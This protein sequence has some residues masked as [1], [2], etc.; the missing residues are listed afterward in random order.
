METVN[1]I[2]E[3]RATMAVGA[4]RRMETIEDSITLFDDGEEILPGILARATFGH[5]PGH[6]SFELRSGSE[7]VMVLGDAITTPHVG[8][9]RPGWES[10]SDQDPTAGAATRVRL[11][12]QLAHEQMILVGYHLPGGGIGRA[13]RNGDTYR[14]VPQGS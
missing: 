7:S 2:P 6:M 13:E 12:D 9:E 10:G 14:F 5:T 1:T 8:F 3:A 11:L 4:R